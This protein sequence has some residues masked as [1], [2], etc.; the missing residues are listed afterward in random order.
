MRIPSRIHVS[1]VSLGI[2]ITIPYPTSKRG[3]APSTHAVARPRT[4][5]AEPPASSRATEGGMTTAFPPL[6]RIL[7]ATTG[8]LSISDGVRPA[9]R[10]AVDGELDNLRAALEEDPEAREST[11]FGYTPL[12]AAAFYGNTDCLKLLLSKGATPDD[13]DD[14]STATGVRPIM[15]A[16]LADHAACVRLLLA[17]GVVAGLLACEI[18][19][20]GYSPL[21]C[22]AEV[23]SIG[24]VEAL[25]EAG[26]AELEPFAQR[27]HWALFSACQHGSVDAV[28][29]IVDATP[30][31]ATVPL[32]D[33]GST[34]LMQ[35]CL[36][37]QANVVRLLLSVPDVASSV[38]AKDS[39]GGSAIRLALEHGPRACVLELLSAGTRVAEALEDL[40]RQHWLLPH[41]RWASYPWLVET[42]LPLGPNPAYWLPLLPT[43]LARRALRMPSGTFLC[44]DAIIM[45]PKSQPIFESGP[46]EAARAYAN[47]RPGN[48]GESARL[49]IAASHPWCPDTHDLFPHAARR[50]VVELVRVIYLLCAPNSGQHRV[51]AHMTAWW[52]VTNLIPN[53]VSRGSHPERVLA[54]TRML[55]ACRRVSQA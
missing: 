12:A 8:L 44:L 36:F 26:A 22:A 46:L 19:E 2:P 27:G 4:R 13:V 23:N 54:P 42:A 20:G 55:P 33:T 31:A 32:P 52:W 7:T 41:E 50:R 1:I 28:A 30:T 17:A 35:A 21:Q 3:A 25:L 45:D 6:K 29:R 34:P 11:S 53:V 40:G 5:D 37:G 9:I 51:W 14:F 49:V 43:D 18:D 24:C 16:C 15:L 10:H 39:E 47:E 48:D 38:N